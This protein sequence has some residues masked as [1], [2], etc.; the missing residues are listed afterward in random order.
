MP[1]LTP[2]WVLQ[3]WGTDLARKHFHDDIWVASLENKI[4]KSNTNVVISDCRFPNEV[5]AIHDLGG[6]IIRVQRGE[7]PEWYPDAELA[8]KG[9]VVAINSLKDKNIHISEWAWICSKYD[10]LIN[11]DGNVDELYGKVSEYIE[12]K[13]QINIT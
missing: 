2:R 10:I 9:S 11:N 13:L 5:Q 12:N 4:I 1:T 7:L 3:F 6:S 8:V